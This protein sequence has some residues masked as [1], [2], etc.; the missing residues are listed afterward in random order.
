MKQL[1]LA[2]LFFVGVGV[3]KA[4]NTVENF[5]VGPY[6]VDYKG[7][8]DVNY[9]LRDDIDLYKFFGLKK[10]TVIYKK[11]DVFIPLKKGVQVNLSFSMPRYSKGVTNVW[12]IDGSWKQNIAKSTYFNAGLLFA[13]SFG[14]Y[15]AFDLNEN[16]IEVGVPLSVEFGHICKNKSSLFGGIGV[17]PTFYSTTKSE[18]SGVNTSQESSEKPSGIFV[19]PRL[20]FGGYIPVKDQWIRMSV[21]GQYN[22]NC[23]NKDNDQFDEHIGRFFIGVSLGLVF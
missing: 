11:K 13:M 17:V 12:A 7:Q 8:G 21:Y 5:N 16:M 1:L 15:D 18:R 10:D 14:K 22:V 3:A 2:T 19:A 23:S 20:D 4:Q 6:E 9:R